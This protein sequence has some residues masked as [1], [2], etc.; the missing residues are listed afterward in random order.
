MIF[1]KPKAKIHYLEQQND[2]KSHPKN[3]HRRASQHRTQ[4]TAKSRLSRRRLCPRPA[5]KSD[6]PPPESE[7]NR[8][9][10]AIRCSEGRKPKRN[11]QNYD[12][13]D[14]ERE[15]TFFCFCLLTRSRDLFPRSTSLPRRS[16]GDRRERQREDGPLFF[17]HGCP[18]VPSDCVYF[19]Y[20]S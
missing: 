19:I 20:F 16:N 13:G 11:M 3:P 1:F 2:K 4:S 14:G 7:S 8:S 15:G 18:R 9:G 10:T 17:L 12:R 6:G 5:S